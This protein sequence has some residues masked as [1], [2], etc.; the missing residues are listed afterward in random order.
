MGWRCRDLVCY[1]VSAVK[2]C[3]CEKYRYLWAKYFC[4]ETE[5]E[6]DDIVTDI[7][8]HATKLFV[9]KEDKFASYDETY[10]NMCWQFF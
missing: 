7:D 4:Y 9:N 8:E 3:A 1:G 10:K 6:I 2:F 5:L